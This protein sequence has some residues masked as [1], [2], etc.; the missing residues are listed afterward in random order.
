MSKLI[1]IGGISFI[2][3]LII[4]AAVGW[5]MMTR[6]PLEEISGRFPQESSL[7]S[8]SSSTCG[9]NVGESLYTTTRNEKLCLVQETTIDKLKAICKKNKECTGFVLIKKNIIMDREDD[10]FRKA[11]TGYLLSKS[12]N[13]E[14]RANPMPDSVVFYGNTRLYKK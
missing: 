4:G 10:D 8:W 12:E 1:I 9:N 3:L 5:F 13:Y 11:N 14:T 6:K 7:G 2:L